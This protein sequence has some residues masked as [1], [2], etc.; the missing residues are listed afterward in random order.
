[1]KVILSAKENISQETEKII[2]DQLNNIDVIE[3]DNKEVIELAIP[4]IIELESLN[5]Q[6]NVLIDPETEQVLDEPMPSTEEQL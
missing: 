4:N 6:Q 5:N 3:I 1:M 2:K